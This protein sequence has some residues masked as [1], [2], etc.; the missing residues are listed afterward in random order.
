MLLPRIL[1]IYLARNFLLSLSIT[2][3]LIS[4]CIFFANI[5]DILNRLKATIVP[6]SVIGKLAFL[7]MPYLIN[8]TLPISILISILFFS[9]KLSR[10]NE[11]II[12]FSDGISI[13]KFL[14]PIFFITLLLSVISIAIMQ[15]ISAYLLTKQEI[16]EKKI[17]N[18]RIVNSISIADGGLYI[19]ENIDDESRIYITKSL[20]PETS[21]LLGITIISLD[22]NY[23]FIKRIDSPIAILNNKKLEL[24]QGA[25]EIDQEGEAKYYPYIVLD[26]NLDFKYIIDRFSSPE[27]IAFW[28]LGNLAKKLTESGI[29]A[30]K[31]IFHY[32]KLLFKPIYI[33]SLIFI[34]ACFIRLNPRN[35]V[36]V[37]MVGSAVIVALIIHSFKEVMTAFLFANNFSFAL[38]QL[39]PIII[40][41][42]LST[43][44]LLHKFE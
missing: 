12:L 32:Y 27:N 15:P 22:K 8:E 42:T 30:D 17:T 40:I 3:C 10:R 11:L 44:M 33:L 6:L 38:A 7:K 5:F 31:F 14:Q 34:A 36:G 28:E 25:I 24:F 43:S 26:T 29:N 35:V 9:Y 18:Q 13:W 21:S 19:S 16:L 20:S 1:F 4:S 37:K 2:I 23:N 39:I 41:I